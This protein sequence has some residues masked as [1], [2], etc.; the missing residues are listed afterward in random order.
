MHFGIA[1]TDCLHWGKVE[2]KTVF[3]SFTSFLLVVGSETGDNDGKNPRVRDE[4]EGERWRL[5]WGGC[6]HD[7]ACCNHGTMRGW[8]DEC[9]FDLCS[10]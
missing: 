1:H 2:S 4:A 6:T 8:P 3:F 7:A 10:A 5:C 9:E